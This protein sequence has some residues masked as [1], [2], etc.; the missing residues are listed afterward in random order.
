[1][2]IG[3]SELFSFNQVPVFNMFT[4]LKRANFYMK[5]ASFR[6]VRGYYNKACG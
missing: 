3:E 1:M 2:G 5:L 6:D 4:N